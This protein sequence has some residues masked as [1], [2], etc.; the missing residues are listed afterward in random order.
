MEIRQRHRSGTMKLQTEKEGKES[1]TRVPSPR[2][3]ILTVAPS[4][5]GNRLRDRL[6]KISD[7]Y[8]GFTTTAPMSFMRRKRMAK[9]KSMA[10]IR[11]GGMRG[12]QAFLSIHISWNSVR[13]GRFFI[14]GMTQWRQGIQRKKK[15]W[16]K[17]LEWEEAALKLGELKRWET[18]LDWDW[19]AK[20]WG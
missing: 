3:Q 18:E 16:D 11:Q 15:G 7:S 12:S 10:T 6:N 2:S 19:E 9:L 17:D 4:L 8:R 5:R 1:Q 14:R 13:K 20:T